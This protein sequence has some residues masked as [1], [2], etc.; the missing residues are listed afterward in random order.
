MSDLPPLDC[1]ADQGLPET[2][3]PARPCLSD[4]FNQETNPLHLPV[5]QGLG[6][7][8][9][10][11]QWFSR[12]P[13]ESAIDSN[14]YPNWDGVALEPLGRY[15]I[16]RRIGRGGMGVVYEA[17]DRARHGAKVAVKVPFV[18]VLCSPS[19][20][21]R[22]DRE[23]R[24]LVE[25]EHPHICRVLDTG[26]HESVPYLVLQYLGGGNLRQ[27]FLESPPG[28]FP[29]TKE[30]LLEWIAPIAKALDFVHARGFVHRDVKPENI[31]F[32]EHG[33]V[34]LSDFG[35]VRAIQSLR[36]DNDISLT[37]VES[38]VG[39]P[40]YMAPEIRAGN[41]VDGKA[42][43]F[44]LASVACVFITGQIP[45]QDPTSGDIQLKSQ[46][47]SPVRSL[48]D[49]VSGREHAH[50]VLTA[51]E[52]SVLSRAMSANPSD[53]FDNCMAFVDALRDACLIIPS[54]MLELSPR[55]SP[56]RSFSIMSP[57]WVGLMA[58]S[59]LFA[60]MLWQLPNVRTATDSIG[61]SKPQQAITEHR[62]SEDPIPPPP[63]TEVSEVVKHYLAAG[64]FSE[65][66]SEIKSLGDS[67]QDM[68]LLTTKAE[69]LTGLEQYVEALQYWDQIVDLSPS[70]E[71]Y[72]RRGYCRLMSSDAAGALEDLDRA[73][74]RDATPPFVHGY[75]GW[76]LLSLHRFAESATAF[77]EALT[78]AA[79]SATATERASW[80]N[81]R[82]AAHAQLGDFD[83]AFVDAT[84]AIQ[85]EPSTPRHLRNRADILDR[86]NR[87][88]EAR[89][90]RRKADEIIGIFSGIQP[91]H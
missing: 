88:E 29:R 61:F 50:S 13:I 1:G 20:H 60:F 86:L 14:A 43:Q 54:S 56:R 6:R 39:T 28:Q 84:Q 89:V 78:L 75:R 52:L 51:A 27:K 18:A 4:L 17:S 31:L 53:R 68:E 71:S 10:S 46:H 12:S 2:S 36:Q 26:R 40:G 76:A 9:P 72:A 65:T 23:F 7:V 32:D 91:S 87:P 47:E 22:F 19:L 41:V 21:E 73:V 42:D 16:S 90:D 64:E 37:Q 49:S 11:Q 62:K 80:F 70:C 48:S 24:A 67:P 45:V 38:P 35:I 77:S 85:L 79:D 55:T 5:D 30:N 33:S 15:E 74:A 69:S 3:A 59:V 8:D 81:G 58:M 83:A 25:L 34:Y 57:R 66:L 82:G 63:K 44:S